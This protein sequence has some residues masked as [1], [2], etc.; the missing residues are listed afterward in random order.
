MTN[1]I[2]DLLHPGVTVLRNC[3]PPEVVTRAFAATTQLLTRPHHELAPFTRPTGAR[4]GGYVPPGSEY[5]GKHGADLERS[6]FDFI[7]PSQQ[8]PPNIDAAAFTELRARLTTI[9]GALISALDLHLSQPLF[10]HVHGARHML[11]LTQYHNAAARPDHALFPAHVDFTLLTLIPASAT[12]GLE[13]F[14]DDAWRGITGELGDVIVFRGSYL[15]P[16]RADLTPTRHRVM[17]TGIDRPSAILFF[18]PRPETI[19]PGTGETYHDRL[20]RRL[21]KIYGLS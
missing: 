9:G 1:P 19:I 11:R 3:V 7:E 15:A 13:V 16:W 14:I 17:A 21:R 10:R 12:P 20:L 18:E 2:A 4:L 5:V 8:L 6:S